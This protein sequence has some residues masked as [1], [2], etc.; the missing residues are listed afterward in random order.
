MEQ[1]GSYRIF[2][3]KH[4]FGGSPTELKRLT[5]QE[6]QEAAKKLEENGY[7][8][9]KILAPAVSTPSPSV[10]GADRH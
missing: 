7:T 3:Q 10:P 4:Q 2:G 9:V 6:A 8:E 5:Q 1:E